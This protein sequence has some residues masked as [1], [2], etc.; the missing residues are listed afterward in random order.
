MKIQLLNGG[1]GNQ[2]FQYIFA[3]FVELTTDD[4]VY[5]DDSFFYLTNMHNGYELERVFPHS[6]P[7]LLSKEFEPKHWNYLLENK[8]KDISLCQ[9][10]KNSGCDVFIIAESG[11][12]SFD[13][14]YVMVPPNSFLPAI[15]YSQGYPYYH[16]Y[17]INRD[18]LY[19][20]LDPL[21]KELTFPD[22][23]DTKNQEYM[24]RIQE[25]ESI[26]IHIRRGD[27]LTCEWD[28]PDSFYYS[29]IAKI[30]ELIPE[31]E[32]FVF[33]DDISYCKSHSSELGFDFSHKPTVFVEGNMAGNNYIDMQLMSQCKGMVISRS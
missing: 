10:L 28:L 12:F 5:L 11:D 21:L 4:I 16:G 2:V 18:W 29:S 7:H 26:A 30:C 32:L 27:F 13:G 19:S 31:A 33:S 15:A 25:T 3:R 9:S 1:L 14:N 17:W 8:K 6:C 23:P 20:F 22:I 24:Q